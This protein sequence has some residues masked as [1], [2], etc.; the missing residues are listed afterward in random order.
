M[1]MQSGSTLSQHAQEQEMDDE[2]GDEMDD[3]QAEQIRNVQEFIGHL[4]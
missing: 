4:D 1:G 2:S 3:E